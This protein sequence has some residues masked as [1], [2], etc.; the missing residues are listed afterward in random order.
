MIRDEENQLFLKWIGNTSGTDFVSD[1]VVNPDE[2]EKM[3][4]HIVF[5]LKESNGFRGDLRGFLNDGG[6]WMTWNNVARWTYAIRQ[7]FIK[8][9]APKWE[10]ARRIYKE[11]RKYNL[12][13]IA[14]VN[15]KKQVGTATTN[16]QKLVEAFRKYNKPFLTDQLN[17]LNPIDCLVCCGNGVAACY[18]ESIREKLEWQDVHP[19][20]RK[21]ITQQGTLVID[22]FHPQSRQNAKKLFMQFC[23]AIA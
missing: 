5:L 19:H 17:L 6:R 11:A 18:E 9:E 23:D 2:W 8:N 7:K 13:K 12:R 10:S 20:V 4:I 16:T 22:F 15:V 3:P 21:A 14:V 1:G